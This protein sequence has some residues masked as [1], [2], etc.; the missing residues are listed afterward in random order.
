MKDI[1]LKYRFTDRVGRGVYRVSTKKQCD[2]CG[3]HHFVDTGQQIRFDLDGNL[4][5]KIDDM[6]TFETVQD[7]ADE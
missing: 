3:D 6:I 1:L 5:I 4:R 7:E 2:T